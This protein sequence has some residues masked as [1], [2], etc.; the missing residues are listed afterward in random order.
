M[1]YLS[2]IWKIFSSNFA[3]TAIIISNMLVYFYCF[4]PRFKWYLYP[5]MVSVTYFSLPMLFEFSHVFLGTTIP[6]SVF[7]SFLGYWDILMV[8]IA[9]RSGFWKIISISFV[10]CI[11]NRLFTFWGY[12]L[13]IPLNSLMGLNVT[14]QVSVTLAIS[15]M[16]AII[17]L[18]CWLALNDKCRK[19]L[20]THLPNHNWVVL[21]L[22]SVSA[23]LT[24]DLCSDFVFYINPYSQIK[25]IWAMIALSNFVLA[26]IALYIHSTLTTLKHFKLKIATDRFNFEKDAQ[27]RY[28]ETQLHNQKE[29]YRMKHDMTGNLNTIF[30]LLSE[31]NRDEALCYV[32]KLN[33][34]YESH[35]KVL[36][37][38]DPY[39]NAVVTNYV[40]SFAKHDIIFEHDIEACKM[41]LYHVEMCL[42]LNNALQN[43]LEASL[44]LPPEDRYVKLQVKTN[45]N[46]FLFRITNRFNGKIVIDNELPRSS[47]GEDGHGYGLASIYEAIESIGGFVVYKIDGNMFILDVAINIKSF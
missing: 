2:Y 11:L 21:A 38:N 5:I 42:M 19:L 46:H 24:I 27:E 41:E 17:F 25:I 14:T 8:L 3:L 47:K 4:R 29:L 10:L 39:L 12:M 22:I 1:T 40:A 18:V 32:A 44:K 9:F 26:V 13:Y 33:D 37:S 15:V 31:N 23:K 34:Y 16:Y 28:Y 7:M 35:Q 30:H 45:Q 36:Y 20:Q 43:A 6:S